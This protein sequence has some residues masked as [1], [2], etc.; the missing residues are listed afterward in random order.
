MSAGR[1]FRQFVDLKS[2]FGKAPELPFSKLLTEERIKRVLDELK[3][4][5]RDR[6][7]SPW[8]TLW[9]FVRQVLNADPSCR[10]VVAQLSAFRVARGL[11]PCSTET[12]AYCQ[13]RQRL[14]E[15]L[16]SR[17]VQETGNE[18]HEEAPG[19]WRC[20]GRPIKI[21][22]G[23][24]V[25]MPDTAENEA[26]FGKPQNQRGKSGFPLARI[27]VIFCL[28]TGAALEVAIGRYKGKNTGELSLFRSVQATLK[29]GDIALGDRLFC[30][31]FDI[32]RLM[33]RGVDG[34]F[35]QH[36]HRHTDFR[37]GKK[38]G[39]EDHLVKWT[40]PKSHNL[41]RSVMCAAALEKELPVRSISFKGTMQHLNAFHLLLTTSGPEK[42]EA[43]CTVLLN[44]VSEHR[45]GNR[46]D[47]YE[48]RKCK[49][50]A[51]PYPAMKLSRNEERKLCL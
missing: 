30:T 4:L 24:T 18:L 46:P 6:I 48:P 7:Y 16:L 36:T 13:A 17:L 49:R 32:A 19:G 21:V 42:L 15:E 31:C 33:Q 38:L 51:K 22:D 20:F 5:Y 44:A 37:R 50:A 2:K 39:P 11:P 9:L 1:F 29:N 40:K 25:S 34:V 3:V 12:G 47:R 23:S 14:P 43:L 27:L 10:N 26:A 35:R 8:V 41:I 28:A 45:V